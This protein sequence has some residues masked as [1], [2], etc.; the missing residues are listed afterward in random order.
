MDPT[1]K[2]FESALAELD[3]IVRKMEEGDLSLETSMELYE[4][5]LQ[6][7]RF[8]HST[9][10][11]AE[12]RIELLNERGELRPAPSLLGQTDDSSRRSP[13]GAEAEESERRR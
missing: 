5:G 11:S 9:L 8:C 12:R 2:D 7:S 10:E 4:R 6:L 13:A 3:G 1:I